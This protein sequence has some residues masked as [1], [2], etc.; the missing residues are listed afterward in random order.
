MVKPQADP[1]VVVTAHQ[2]WIGASAPGGGVRQFEDASLGACADRRIARDGIEEACKFQRSLAVVGQ[3]DKILGRQLLPQPRQF[4]CILPAMANRVYL[5]RMHEDAG[6][7]GGRGLKRNWTSIILAQFEKR[8]SVPSHAR[9][10]ALD[11]LE[12]KFVF[13]I[14]C[15]EAEL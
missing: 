5:V 15:F 14:V 3:K 4:G 12:H 8:D 2:E 1:T 13:A 7:T 11:Q 9:T 10:V 6:M